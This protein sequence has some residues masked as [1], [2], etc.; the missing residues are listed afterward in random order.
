MKPT[1]LRKLMQQVRRGDVSPDEAVEQLRHL[2]FEELGFAKVDHHRALRVGV[3]E[4]I[5]GPGKTPANLASIFSKLAARNFSRAFSPD[6]VMRAGEFLFYRQ[7]GGDALTGLF[8]RPAA[9]SQP[10]ALGSGRTGGANYPVELIFRPRF[11]QERDD[12]HGERAVFFAPL[13]HLR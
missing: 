9:R 4:V 11:K 10:F 7:L 8:G 6:D 12:D 1:E 2:P 3:P 13:R 5:F